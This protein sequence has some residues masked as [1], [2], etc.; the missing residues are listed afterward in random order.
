MAVPAVVS[1][2]AALPRPALAQPDD[3]PSRP[4]RVVVPFAA[5][6][7]AD[8]LPRLIGQ[9]LSERW[10]K[11]EVIDNKPGAAGNIGMEVAAKAPADGYT[12]VMAGSAMAINQTLYK[13]V[14][15]D[16]RQDFA[17][18]SLLA[19]VPNVLVTNKARNPQKTVAEVI[20]SARAKP[21]KYTYASAGNGTSIHLA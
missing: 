9:K 12:L 6:G 10:G 8:A 21:G 20:A 7:V 15:Y 5:G 19:V 2:L 14:N 17:P 4:V 18:V 1:V 11:P 16:P 13:K 3:Y